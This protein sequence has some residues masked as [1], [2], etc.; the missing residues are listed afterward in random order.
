MPAVVN[1]WMCFMG[2]AADLESIKLQGRVLFGL[3]SWQSF[4]SH[5]LLM[6]WEPLQCAMEANSENS[7]DKEGAHSAVSSPELPR[8]FHHFR[9]HKDQCPHPPCHGGPGGGGEGVTCCMSPKWP[10]P[11]CLNE[12]GDEQNSRV[13]EPKGVL[14]V[15]V[16]LFVESFL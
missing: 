1:S 4:P 12:A 16:F 6:I 3:L 9:Q 7:G 2:Q 14:I 13:W 5:V 10:A 15:N 11:F 8:T